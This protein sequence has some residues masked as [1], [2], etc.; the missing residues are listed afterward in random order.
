MLPMT[1]RSSRVLLVVD[2]KREAPA[3]PRIRRYRLAR[4]QTDARAE[5]FAHLRRSHD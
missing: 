1:A 4:V 2:T 3:D 5:R